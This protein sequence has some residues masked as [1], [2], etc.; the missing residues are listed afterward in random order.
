MKRIQKIVIGSLMALFVIFIGSVDIG[1]SQKSNSD[2]PP[3]ESFPD[4]EVKQVPG[5]KIVFE[6]DF[7]DFGQIPYNR[8]VTHI[9]RF[10]NAG[11]SPLLLARRASSKPIE[12][13]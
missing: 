7:F 11:T 12:G 13:C 4:R 5:S 8:K 10:Q 6:E 3:G 2:Q 1:E 9:F